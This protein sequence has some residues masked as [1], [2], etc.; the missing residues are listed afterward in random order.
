MFDI[1]ARHPPTSAARSAVSASLCSMAWR[2]ASK[3]QMR[4]S[5]TRLA[6]RDSTA[7]DGEFSAR[8]FT[9]DVAAS[10]AVVSVPV[11]EGVVALAVAAVAAPVVAGGSGGTVSMDPHAV[12]SVMARNRA[13][14]ARAHGCVRSSGIDSMSSRSSP[15]KKNYIVC[16]AAWG[17]VHMCRRGYTPKLTSAAISIRLHVG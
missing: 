14:S 8:V 17:G 5:D 7:P 16:T 11:A 6:T 15:D 3:K 12:L 10:T 4:C 1:T 9:A 2:E 13:C